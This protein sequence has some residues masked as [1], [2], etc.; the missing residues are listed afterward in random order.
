MGEAAAPF[1]TRR[2]SA[3]VTV[4]ADQKSA[5]SLAGPGVAVVRL[6]PALHSHDAGSSCPA[7]EAQGDVRVA[8]FELMHRERTGDVPQFTSV[9]IDASPRASCSS[10]PRRVAS[11][12]AAK[13][14]SKR[15]CI[16]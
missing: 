15:V 6:A 4:V 12:N 16:Y 1:A 11:D 14:E 7:C 5:A 8:L 2:P 3:P 10:T 9:V 13:E